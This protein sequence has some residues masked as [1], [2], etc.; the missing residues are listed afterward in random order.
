MKTLLKIIYALFQII[1]VEKPGET[2]LSTG[3]LMGD[4]KDEIEEKYGKRAEITGY[5]STGPKSYCLIISDKETGERLDT[6]V[7]VKGIKP[8]LQTET[9]I[10]AE[11]LYKVACDD[12]EVCVNQNLMKRNRRDGKVETMMLRKRFQCTFNKRLRLENEPCKTL[13]I[14]WVL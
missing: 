9:I 14:G 2:R 10:T 4:F 8:N 7:K 12:F 6:I 3:D 5:A 11:T 1:Y 13:P